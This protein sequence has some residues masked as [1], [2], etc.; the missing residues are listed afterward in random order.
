MSHALVPFVDLYFGLMPQVFLIFCCRGL[1]LMSG[2]RCDPI[3]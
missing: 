3:P 2:I 1:M